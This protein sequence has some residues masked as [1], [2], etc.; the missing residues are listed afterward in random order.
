MSTAIILRCCWG[1]SKVVILCCVCCQ[2]LSCQGVS[3][4]R[5]VGW[6]TRECTSMPSPE[7][8]FLVGKNKMCI[9]GITV[10]WF[11]SYGSHSL[12][13]TR[14]WDAVD[15]FGSR[16]FAQ[17]ICLERF[18]RSNK[19]EVTL[20]TYIIYESNRSGKLLGEPFLHFVVHEFDIHIESC[21]ILLR[22]TCCLQLLRWYA[23]FSLKSA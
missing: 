22:W 6:S 13:L 20:L 15:G 23:S 19:S 10:A 9:I 4:R 11:C 17:G 21:V 8:P 5:A 2:L 12:I 14:S 16:A 7:I 3:S 18:G 1:C